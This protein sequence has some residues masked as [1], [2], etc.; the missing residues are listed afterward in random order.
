LPTECSSRTKHTRINDK[1]NTV[2]A[3]WLFGWRVFEKVFGQDYRIYR[4][5]VNHELTRRDTKLKPRIN[6]DFRGLNIWCKIFFHNKIENSLLKNTHKEQEDERLY[7]E[8]FSRLWP[9]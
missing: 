7:Y 9:L 4:D 2:I 5:I 1:N 8:F 6:A 3:F